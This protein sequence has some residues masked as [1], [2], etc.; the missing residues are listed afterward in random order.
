MRRLVLAVVALFA[1]V[2]GAALQAAYAG[3]APAPAPSTYNWTGMYF[4]AHVGGGWAAKDWTLV[5]TPA[6]CDNGPG[7]A[8]GSG[9][10]S[11]LLGGLQAGMN[12]QQGPVVFGLQG[13]VSFAGINGTAANP[14]S[15]QPGNC[16]SGG[17]Q[18]ARCGSKTDWLASVT[19]R[20]GVLVM[21][22]TLLYV[23]GGFAFAHDVFSVTDL[24]ANQGG[25]YG[26]P[27]PDYAAVGQGRTGGTVGFGGEHAFSNKVTMFAEYDYSNFGTQ[28]VDFPDTG[29]G[30]SPGFTVAIK[31]SVQEVKVG[32]NVHY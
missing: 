1:I 7:A 6:C 4:G 15:A 24:V 10:G 18:T 19:A 26:N 2:S 12:W 20:A 32:F 25:C 3:P 21:P 27:G 13:D 29:N 23:K 30:C 14:A 16:W 11:G 31:Q 22:D 5:A 28:N 17:D 9:T 8:L